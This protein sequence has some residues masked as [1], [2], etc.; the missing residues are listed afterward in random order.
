MYPGPYDPKGFMYVGWKLGLPTLDPDRA[1]ETMVGDS[2]TETLVVGKTQSELVK[3]FGYVTS[4]NDAAPY[5][6]FCY[7]TSGYKGSEATFLRRSN[8]MVVMK[9]GRA[10]A[11]VLM[12]GC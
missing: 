8:W 10:T 2:H 9:D 1:L 3:R 4:L 12:K 11:L 7:N 6:K 5:Y